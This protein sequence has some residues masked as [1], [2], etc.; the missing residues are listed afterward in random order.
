M[1]WPSTFASSSRSD[2]LLRWQEV[3]A[4]K[5][6]SSTNMIKAIKLRKDGWFLMLIL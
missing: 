2:V 4:A 5:P 6:A 1:G 3:R